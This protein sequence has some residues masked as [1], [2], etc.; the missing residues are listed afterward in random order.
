MHGYFVRWISVTLEDLKSETGAKRRHVQGCLQLLGYSRSKPERNQ[1]P[2]GRLAKQ[3]C[4]EHSVLLAR[5]RAD[6]P[7]TEPHRTSQKHPPPSEEAE[8]GARIAWW[9]MTTDIHSSW[10]F[11]TLWWQKPAPWREGRLEG[12][13]DSFCHD[14][15]APALVWED[16]CVTVFY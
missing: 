12:H 15:N 16:F 5:Q 10:G 2:A 7:H 13:K 1:T 4:N 8:A 3:T 14:E 11:I 9:Q 6:Q